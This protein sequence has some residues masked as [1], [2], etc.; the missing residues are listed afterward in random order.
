ML[1]NPNTIPKED[2]LIED[3][4]MEPFFISKAKSGAGGFTVFER[5]IKGAND[6]AY[7]RTVCYPSTFTSALRTVAKELLNSGEQ[8]KYS[9][10]KEYM[11]KWDAITT[12]MEHIVSID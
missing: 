12:K 11:Q 7:I 6:T 10:V 3:P 1:R 4:A 2:I 8:T 5:V 9:S